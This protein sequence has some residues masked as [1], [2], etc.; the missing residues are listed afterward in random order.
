MDDKSRKNPQES[1]DINDLPPK[2]LGKVVDEYVKGGAEP[3]NIKGKPKPAEP[4]TDGR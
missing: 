1:L 4:I 3:P 2:K